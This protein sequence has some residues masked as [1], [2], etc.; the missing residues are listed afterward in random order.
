MPLESRA[1][2]SADDKPQN[3]TVSFNVTIKNVPEENVDQMKLEINYCLLQLAK[4]HSPEDILVN[5]IWY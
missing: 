5:L 3:K 2:P 1:R 4:K